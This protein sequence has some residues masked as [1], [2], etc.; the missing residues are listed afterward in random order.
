MDSPDDTRP[1]RRAHRLRQAIT[2]ALLAGVVWIIVSRL[3]ELGLA[4]VLAELPTQPAYYVL[5]VLIYL[6]LPLSEVFIYHRLWKTPG[7]RLAPV[8]FRKRVLNAGVLGYSGEAYLA[9]WGKENIKRPD[10]R[11]LSTIK[12]NNLVSSFVSTT[13]TIALAVIALGPSLFASGEEGRPWSMTA[14]LA[15]AAAIVAA[16]YAFRRRVL[17]IR[18]PLLNTVA[19]THALRL[20]AVLALQVLQ[21]SLVLPDVPLE[22]WLILMAA[23]MLATRIPFLPS[24]DLVLLGLGLSLTGVVGAPEAAMAGLFLAGAALS[25]GANLIVLAATALFWRGKPD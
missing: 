22:N 25:Q 24:Y 20:N 16:G 21:W 23:F 7:E 15:A 1:P 6:A 2:I 5:F 17:S 3:W 11:V 4:N 10:V 19:A 18:G 14:G 12:D 13:T 9:V 8:L